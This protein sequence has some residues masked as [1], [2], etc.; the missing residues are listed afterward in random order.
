[1]GINQLDFYGHNKVDVAIM[2]IKEFCPPDGY[3]LAFSGGKDSVVIYDLALKAGV[4]FDAHYNCGIEPA[5]LVRFV[6]SEYTNVAIE[7]LPFNF[8]KLVEEK[9]LPLRRR[10]WCCEYLRERNGG[11][12]VVMTGVRSDESAGRKKRKILDIGQ[13]TRFGPAPK[14]V[15]HPIIDW[16]SDDVWEYIHV[17]KV[18]YCSL[19]DEG[20]DRLGCV[21]CPLTSQVKR[22]RELERFPKMANCWKRATERLYEN[23]KISSDFIRSWKSWE[24]MWDWWLGLP[25][26]RP[27]ENYPCRLFG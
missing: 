23:K 17:N 6:R 4:L 15:L 5:E 22:M 27:D 16:T 26:T 1:M 10:R 3:Y 25:D 8:W 9:G 13:K 18:K 2:R 7:K 19:Y 14:Y 20:F 11:G 21:L 12:R 24:E